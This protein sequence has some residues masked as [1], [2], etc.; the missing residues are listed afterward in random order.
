MS[1]RVFMLIAARLASADP[2]PDTWFSAYLTSIN[3]VGYFEPVNLIQ[4]PDRAQVASA[5]PA[6]ATTSYRA[7]I[8]C[9]IL[10]NGKLT[11]CKAQDLWPSKKD[12][13]ASISKI[14][15]LFR[16]SVQDAALAKTHNAEVLLTMYLDDRR[17]PLD[18]SCPAGWCPTIPPP[19]PPPPPLP[20]GS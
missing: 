20:N 5:I 12:T 6:S 15:R 18:R 9:S 19:P 3:G 11:K 17:R 1:A 13:F 2:V 16:L 14:I 7:N 10:P 8:H 4:K